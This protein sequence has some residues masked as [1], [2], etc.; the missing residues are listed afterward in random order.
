MYLASISKKDLLQILLTTNVLLCVP[1]IDSR[2]CSH[3]T[4]GAKVFFPGR[5]GRSMM[6]FNLSL[7]KELEGK[8]INPN[9]QKYHINGSRNK[10]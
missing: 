5:C 2:P 4:R 9:V 6:N 3:W 1:S 8:Q 10:N 7:R